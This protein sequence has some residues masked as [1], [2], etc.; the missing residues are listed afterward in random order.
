VN[1]R[2]SRRSDQE[3][4]L[5]R[6]FGKYT[7]TVAGPPTL[8]LLD[9]RR[10]PIEEIRR[11]VEPDVRYANHRNHRGRRPLWEHRGRAQLIAAVLPRWPYLGGGRRRTAQLGR[12]RRIA[13][14]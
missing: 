8:D 3:P 13:E 10:E 6:W 14:V 5:A 1:G 7:A 11:E 9:D 12:R 4:A 2:T